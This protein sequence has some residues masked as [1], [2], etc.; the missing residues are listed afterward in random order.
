VL[1]LRE[2]HFGLAI[3]IGGLVNAYE[4]LVGG[5]SCFAGSRVNRAAALGQCNAK[6]TKQHIV[7]CFVL[8]VSLIPGS[9]KPLGVVCF[10]VG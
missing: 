8:W 6:Q 7:W 9:L 5:V 10:A 3:S 2:P 1:G 4:R